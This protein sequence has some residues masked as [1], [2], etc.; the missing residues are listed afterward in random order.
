V[1][2]DDVPVPRAERAPADTL[3]DETPVELTPPADT[4]AGPA[5]GAAAEVPEA[6]EATDTR[7]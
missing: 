1:T 7:R 5:P 3:P 2:P 4:E 6:S